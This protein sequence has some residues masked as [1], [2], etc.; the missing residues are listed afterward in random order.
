MLLATAGRTP[1]HKKKAVC[2]AGSFRKRKR[3]GEHNKYIEAN[4]QHERAR[5]SGKRDRV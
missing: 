5:A 4:N 2:R 3:R 1:R